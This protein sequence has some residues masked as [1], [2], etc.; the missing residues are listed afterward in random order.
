MAKFIQVGN[1]RINLD[2]IIEV[3]FTPAHEYENGE[4]YE[5]PVMEHFSASIEITTREI[6]P[7]RVEDFRGNDM[8]R[9]GV[10]RVI[11]FRGE[12]AELINAYFENHADVYKIL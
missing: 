9:V 1:Q 7:R 11:T 6:Y 2:S 12:P 4:D 8:G 10:S 5:T 3:D